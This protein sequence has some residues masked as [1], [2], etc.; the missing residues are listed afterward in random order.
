[1]AVMSGG[2]VLVALAFFFLSG[3]GRGLGLM[4]IVAF[5]AFALFFVVVREGKVQE[6]HIMEDRVIPQAVPE[7]PR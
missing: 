6:R 5:V 7:L 3:Q 4:M 2:I 1:M